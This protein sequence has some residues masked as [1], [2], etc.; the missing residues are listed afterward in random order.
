M[1]HDNMDHSTMDMEM[2]RPTAHPPPHQDEHTTTFIDSH[3]TP[4]YS[5]QWTPASAGSYAATCIF[6][7]V[8]A[9]T[10]RCLVAFKSVLEQRWKAALL[11]RQRGALDAKSTEDGGLERTG[12]GA[13]MGT[14]STAQ[15]IGENDATDRKMSDNPAPFQLMVDLSRALLF[16]VITG[17]SFL[18]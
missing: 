9:V 7:I 6:L 18:L 10:G 1:D 14:V 3:S 17:V 2:P 11:S 12:L 13:K 5:G 8:L 4:L 15:H 16:T